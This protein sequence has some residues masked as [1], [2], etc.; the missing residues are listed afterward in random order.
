MSVRVGRINC[1]SRRAVRVRDR[2]A[3]YCPA[4]GVRRPRPCAGFVV[5]GVVKCDDS[6][7]RITSIVIV[8]ESTPGR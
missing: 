6:I 3:G 8:R 2:F 5:C 7:V 4:A 1:A